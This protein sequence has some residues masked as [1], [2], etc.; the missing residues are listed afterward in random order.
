MVAAPPSIPPLIRVVAAPCHDASGRLSTCR[1]ILAQ[2]LSPFG[3]LD[4]LG[5][6]SEWTETIAST[7]TQDGEPRLDPGCRLAKGAHWAHPIYEQGPRLTAVN[8]C[9]V[10]ARVE[11]LGFRCAR[12]VW[13]RSD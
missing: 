10:Y 6:V 11:W 2:P 5:N 8:T 9:P 3:V 7:Q 1:G 4:V 12:S 13:P